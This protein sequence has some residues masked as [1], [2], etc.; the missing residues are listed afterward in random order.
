MR[1]RQLRTTVVL[2]LAMTGAA[3]SEP[4]QVLIL[5]PYGR[6]FVPW[7][8]YGKSFRE[9]LLRQSPE[10]ID[11]SETSLVSPRSASLKEGPLSPILRPLFL[12]PH[13]HLLIATPTPTTR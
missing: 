7:G 12:N 4:K 10:G 13:P 2:L 9:E 3:L 1:F 6:D 8:E 5:H 11:L